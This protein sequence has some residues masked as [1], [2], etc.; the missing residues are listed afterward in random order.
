MFGR[1][2]SDSPIRPDIPITPMLDMSFQL[3]AFFILTFRPAPVEGQ[4]TLAGPRMGQEVNAWPALDAPAV[5]I[6]RVEARPNG[7]ISNL[8]LREKDAADPRPLDLGVDRARLQA[9]LK[10]RYDGLKDKPGKLILE[11]EPAL[12]QEHVVQLID[13]GV[14]AGFQ[15]IAPILTDDIDLQ[16]IPRLDPRR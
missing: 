4:F 6:V 5:F 7:A 13:A 9:E 3:L 16:G 8:T 10:K 2:F 1:R 15:N 12:L 14:R 11:V